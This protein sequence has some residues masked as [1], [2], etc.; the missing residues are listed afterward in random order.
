[1]Y[2]GFYLWLIYCYEYTENWMLTDL[3]YLGI[4]FSYHCEGTGSRFSHHTKGWHCSRAPS[5]SQYT[6]CSSS[7]IKFSS[8]ACSPRLPDSSDDQ[9]QGL[10]ILSSCCETLLCIPSVLPT[11][12]LGF[13]WGSSLGISK[14]SRVVI[15]MC[16]CRTDE[17]DSKGLWTIWFFLK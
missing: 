15:F 1:M 4:H 16:V 14:T 6:I 12:V 10:I 2:S 5:F 7:D 13:S 11:V 17:T 9:P 8:S 3:V